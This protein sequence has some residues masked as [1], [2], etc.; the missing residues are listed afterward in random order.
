MG[1]FDNISIIGNRVLESRI[2]SDNGVSRVISRD[3]GR[4]SGLP[5]DNK[6]RDIGGNTVGEINGG[7]FR[8]WPGPPFRRP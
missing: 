8:D 3:I 5:F 4:T 6:V 1:L 7:L 2:I